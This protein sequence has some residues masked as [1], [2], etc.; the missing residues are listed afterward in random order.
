MSSSTTCSAHMA[1]RWK[2]LST[3]N[4]IRHDVQLRGNDTMKQSPS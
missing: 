1:S 3:A 4:V 2:M